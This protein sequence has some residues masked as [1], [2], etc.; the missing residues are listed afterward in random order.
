[1]Q[2]RPWD[3]NP[4]DVG[5]ANAVANAIANEVATIKAQ[6]PSLKYVVFAGGD[7]QIPFFRIPDLSLIANESG[8]ASQFAPN[9]YYGALASGD[10]LTDNPYLDTRPVPASGRAALHPRPRRRPARRDADATS[11]TPSRTSR[12]QRQAECVHGVRLRLRL[13]ERRKP[14]RRRANLQAN[15]VSVTS[16]IGDGLVEERPPRR[17]LSPPAGRPTSTTGTA[18]TTTRGR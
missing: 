2:L 10:L 4:C 18:T 5:A 12:T 17:R 16:L 14:D 15:H 9:E 11:S 7:D 13:R 6:R 8:F 3:A 1:M